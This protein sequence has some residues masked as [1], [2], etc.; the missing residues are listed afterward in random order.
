[1]VVSIDNLSDIFMV[2]ANTTKDEAFKENGY[3]EVKSSIIVPSSRHDLKPIQRSL[4][5]PNQLPLS[6]PTT[7]SV[8][9]PMPHER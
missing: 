3:I 9:W 2:A 6:E 5:I 8:P 1:M 4:S 7:R